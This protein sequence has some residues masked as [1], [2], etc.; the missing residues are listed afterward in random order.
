MTLDNLYTP[1]I[2]TPQKNTTTG[3]NWGGG[4]DVRKMLNTTLLTFVSGAQTLKKHKH[5]IEYKQ[6][7]ISKSF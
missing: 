2:Q 1:F 7:L 3:T 5:L 6:K 4:H